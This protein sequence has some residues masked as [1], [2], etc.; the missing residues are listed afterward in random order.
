M[1]SRRMM[2]LAAAV[3]A[4]VPA[5]LAM[6]QGKA[7]PKTNKQV[8]RGE[9]L[10]RVSG[11]NDC[12]TPFAMGPQGSAPDMTRML[13]GHPGGMALPP[14]P[15]AAGN[16]GPWI[17]SFDGTNTAWAGPWGITY[18]ANLT[19]DKETGMGNWTEQNF[20][21][22]MRT[23]KH[24][25]KGRPIFPPMPW[26]NLAAMTDEDLKAVFAFLK[27]IPPIKN[28]VPEPKLNPPPGGAPGGAPPPGGPKK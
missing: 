20:I 6:A 2:L 3:A 28:A 24:M 26:Q 12:H 17:G 19:P 7:K 15:Q 13:S 27:S 4:I 10:V 8:A 14:P 22:A 16:T 18:S 23:G 11:C 25:G 5:G 21:E 9:Y 1:K